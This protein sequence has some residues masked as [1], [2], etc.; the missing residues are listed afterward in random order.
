MRYKTNIQSKVLLFLTFVLSVFIFVYILNHLF[1][2]ME[3]SYTTSATTLNTPPPSTSFNTVPPTPPPPGPPVINSV[4]AVAKASDEVDLTV[5]VNSAASSVVI[6]NSTAGS[7]GTAKSS[8]NGNYS[9]AF[10]GL[11]FNTPYSFTV[12][13]SNSKGD[14]TSATSSATTP[15]TPPP[16]DCVGSWGGWSDCKLHPKGGGCCG[17]ERVYSVTQKKQ[18]NGKDCDHK[19]GDAERQQ[20]NCSGE[21]TTCIALDPPPKCVIS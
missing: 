15:N 19:D 17:Q 1:E 12:T 7:S 5:N 9:Y 20:G 6:A 13:A 14:T 4:S 16:V 10:T 2:G 3:A 11:Q 8:S 21:C 18:G